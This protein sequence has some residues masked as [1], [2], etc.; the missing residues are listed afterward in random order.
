MHWTNNY[1]YWVDGYIAACDIY[2]AE[3]LSRNFS[4]HS[5]G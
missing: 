2:I 4:Q 1:V 3:I 5:F